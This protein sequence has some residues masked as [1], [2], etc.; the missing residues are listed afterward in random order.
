MKNFEH[1][2][3]SALFRWAQLNE[4]KYPALNMLFAVPNG[5]HRHIAVARKLKASGV[6][7]GVPDLFLAWPSKK[8]HGL[9]IE[10][11]AGKNK[12]TVEQ[13]DWLGRLKVAG[14]FADTC[15]GFEQARDTIINYLNGKYD[16]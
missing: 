10:M 13:I 7:A 14:Y 6:K 4:R 12:C 11:K 5:G 1:Q 16:E 8:Y 15:Y 2:E 9:F 3:Q